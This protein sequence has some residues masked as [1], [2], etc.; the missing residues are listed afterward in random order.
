MNT[1]FSQVV[2]ALLALHSLMLG[3]L[4]TTQS[5]TI[6]EPVFIAAGLH[7]WRFGSFGAIDGNPPLSRLIAALPVAMTSAKNYSGRH[8]FFEGNS[9]LIWQITTFARLACIPF[10]LLGAY[11]CFKWSSEM[12]GRPAGLC[13]LVLWCFNPSVLGFGSLA[14]ADMAASAFGVLALFGFWNWLRAPSTSRAVIAGLAIGLALLTKHVWLIAFVICL[15]NFGVRRLICRIYGLPSTTSRPLLHC[16]LI[17]SCA[18][19]VI[20]LGYGFYETCHP[21]SALFESGHDEIASEIQFH[22]GDAAKSLN[23][24]GLSG[25]VGRVPLP[26][27]LP[28]LQGP[29]AIGSVITEPHQNYLRGTWLKGSRWY[30]ILYGLSVKMPIGATLL[31]VWS[32]IETLRDRRSFFGVADELYIF[33]AA[34]IFL[35]FVSA[36]ANPQYVRYA[37]PA[38]PLFAIL[39]AR[40]C[41]GMTY[42]LCTRGAVIVLFMVWAVGSS[43]AVFPHSLSYFNE[44]AGGAKNGRFHLV[45]NATD[46]GQDLFH[47]RRWINEHPEARPLRF[48]YFGVVDPR[49]FG[50]EF[51]LPEP[52]CIE[53]SDGPDESD[54]ELEAGWYAF[55]TT[56]LHGRRWFTPDGSG[57]WKV[58]EQ[59]AF[60]CFQ[61]LEPIAFAGY[62]ILIF[63]V[64]EDDVNRLKHK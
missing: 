9:G 29:I 2:A 12:W 37:F 5:P 17:L 7:H 61:E 53:S 27:P 63:H 3:Y 42:F 52:C 6:D 30:A 43:L 45:D 32:L 8:E 24:L 31:L 1:R 16:V 40:V 58:S 10:S 25:W 48:A 49:H 28:Y 62:S 46:W 20:N 15:V 57:G 38:Q 4:I 19:Y 13:S 39:A 26:L 18:V 41:K 22:S 33:V 36:M 35:T 54:C 60:L 23:R 50:I 56:L 21:A 34:C 11:I 14:T 51:L 47:L 44:V 59:E 55:S 64:T